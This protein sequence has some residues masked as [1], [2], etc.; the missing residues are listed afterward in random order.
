MPIRYLPGKACTA[1]TSPSISAMPCSSST[2]KAVSLCTS[3]SRA[4]VRGGAH[5][6]EA[7]RRTQ[8]DG[9]RRGRSRLSGGDRGGH[10]AIQEIAVLY[11]AKEHLLS[12]L[13]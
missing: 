1:I 3:K 13:R 2:V 8:L 9:H 7:I 10:A 6:N 12:L 11:R 4:K 5:P